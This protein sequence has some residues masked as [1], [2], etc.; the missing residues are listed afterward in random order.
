MDGHK[1]VC[2]GKPHTQEGGNTRAELRNQAHQTPGVRSRSQDIG[3]PTGDLPE[4][5][6]FTKM[7]LVYTIPADYFNPLRCK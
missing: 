5:R 3:V 2:E 4:T 7:N 6:V 1:W